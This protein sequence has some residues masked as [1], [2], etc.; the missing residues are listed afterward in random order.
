MMI[1]MHY[2]LL[3]F[4]ECFTLKPFFVHT[5]CGQLFHWQRVGGSAAHFSIEFHFKLVFLIRKITLNAL[6]SL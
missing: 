3:L 1:W 4:S 6:Q 5:R 2:M